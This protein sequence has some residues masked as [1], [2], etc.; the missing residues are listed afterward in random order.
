LSLCSGKQITLQAKS[1]LTTAPSAVIGTDTLL[2]TA[3]TYP[4]PFGHSFGGSKEQYLIPASELIATGL[5]P[6]NI[7]SLAVDVVQLP[8]IGGSVLQNF[9]IS[10]GRTNLTN[11]PPAVQTGINGM[12]QV[13]FMPFDTIQ[14][15]INTYTFITPF[16]WDG[17]SN[18]LLEI[19][20]NNN[21]N[22]GGQGG[23]AVVRQSLTNY[24]STIGY[25]ISNQQNV[26]STNGNASINTF[27]RR[28]NF[29]L[30]GLVGND[31]TTTL[32]WDWTPGNLSGSLVN[33]QA[34]T[35]GIN[36]YT[37]KATNSFGCTSNAS[38]NVNV[39]GLSPPP[40]A[41]NGSH[42]G[43]K[44]PECSVSGMTGI[45][46]WYLNP[47]GGIPLAGETSA[48]LNSYVIGTTTTFY[49]SEFDGLC[50]SIRVPVTETVI[51]TDS[52]NIIAS[53]P[54]VCQGIPLTL[55]ANQNGNTSNY[56]FN[57]TSSAGG[58]L[59][60]SNGNQVT[61]IPSL[62]GIVTYT[63][64][65]LDITSG[66]RWISN[67]NVTSNLSPAVTAT[68][69]SDS[70]CVGAAN[71]LTASANLSGKALQL[72]GI[73][74]Y[75]TIPPSASLDFSTNFTIELWMNPGSLD[76]GRG[77]L[78]KNQSNPNGSYF[79]RLGN[80]FP[81]SGLAA[82]GMN[83]INAPLG[84]LSLNTWYHVAV[85]YSN[86]SGTNNN[87]SIYLNGNL[88]VSGITTVN[89]NTDSLRIGIDY[90][91]VSFL[92]MIDE[93]RIWNSPLN[94]STIQ[95]WKNKPLDNS[96]PN[97][98]NLKTYFDFNF[99]SG[100]TV[101]DLSGNGNNAIMVNNAA[102]I[103][104]TAPLNVGFSYAWSPTNDLN[105]P[106]I[107]NPGVSSS[108]SGLKTYTV[109]ATSQSGCSSNSTTHFYA[110]VSAQNPV[111][112][113]TL[114]TT[115]FCNTGSDLLTLQNART[116]NQIR[117]QSSTDNIIWQDIPN[118]NGISLQTNILTITT[119][120]R[121][122]VSCT[123]SD[124]SNVIQLTIDVPTIT[125]TTGAT[126]CGSGQVSLQVTGNGNI[127]WFTNSTGSN[128]LF[129]GNIYQPNVSVSTTFWVE[130]NING[131]LF[132]GS[133]QPVVASVIPAPL[134]SSS[135]SA[136]LICSGTA[137]ILS[138]NSSND[139]NYSYVWTP[140]NFHGSTVPVSPNATTVYTVTATD[141]TLGTNNGCIA[142]STT[143]ISVSTTPPVAL[144][145]PSAPAICNSGGSVSLSI[146]NVFPGTVYRWNP[147]NFQGTSFTVSPSTTTTYTVTALRSPGCTSTANVTVYYSPI[148]QPVISSTSS[149][150]ICRG[151]S[152][153]L[154]TSANYSS[155]TW[156][157]GTTNIGSG[158]SITISPLSNFLC[159]LNVFNGLCSVAATQAI[160][161]RPFIPPSIT[162]ASNQTAFCEHD[163][164]LLSI[165]PSY[166]SYSWL[167][168]STSISNAQ[169]LYASSSGI[170]TATV[171]AANGCT[172]S[173]SISI[174]MNPAPPTAI[175]SPAGPILLC[176]DGSNS[177]TI[178][179]ADTTGS[180]PNSTLIWNDQGGTTN[181]SLSIN[182]DDLDIII[183]GNSF[184]YYF[185]ITN[186]FGC[187]NISN[188]V[189]AIAAPCS[190]NVTLNV[191]LFLEGYYTMGGNGLMNNQGAG[192]CLFI[193]GISTNPLD[194]DTITISLAD[195]SNLSIVQSA[196]G[197]LKT[198]GNVNV[199]FQ[200]PVLAGLSYYLIIKHRNSIETW[201][202]NPVMFNLATFYDFTSA[203]TQAY[204]D[205]MNHTSDG[206]FWAIYSG[207]I[208]DALTGS[209][210]IQDGMIESQDYADLENAT[211]II[212]VGYEI[213]DITGDGVVESVDYSI[214]ENNVNQV[215]QCIHP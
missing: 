88:I 1:F 119:Y 152:I 164:L 191:R 176:D 200:N 60:T 132:S 203:Q 135:S 118:A 27:Y 180:G 205:N 167:N 86:L 142:T 139:P 108:N 189:T 117:W 107:Y 134:I 52:I 12:T 159:S 202:S 124:T 120:F 89:I 40:V 158:P 192:G 198:D 56:S 129:N 193:N 122:I 19:C 121:V 104:S 100:T 174:S 11:L 55:I 147:G 212:L 214:M 71:Q 213:E 171:T 130:S 131:C 165:T 57:W 39:Y 168:G 37:V 137:A 166:L 112:A 128:S 177:P 58:G 5:Q 14:T 61:A 50:E 161:V 35:P 98:S 125:S 93:V 43:N 2:N 190:G 184:N 151:D 76:A 9:S 95:S 188:Q 140:G 143:Q 179:Q 29:R 44:V 185:T 13:L 148:I 49:V 105:N 149:F 187:S 199:T 194:V 77:L 17:I 116:G 22:G 34:T 182:H 80:A 208:S 81:F 170:Y 31:L 146:S 123:D 175:I 79:L 74:Q 186:S 64:D 18:L 26:C 207:D 36:T 138:V 21:D 102:I 206:F 73:N 20:F 127:N 99:P 32:T 84:S 183:N 3:S 33:T 83:T 162:S 23:N 54:S 101:P 178:F 48:T 163:S 96:H 110:S 94:I 15:G 153:I 141:T 78:S 215:I 42:C 144:I 172:A 16:N 8:L 72:D 155:Y 7:V 136:N 145:S 38:A 115:V 66:C 156:F 126:R 90:G 195:A 201:S 47:S 103:S 181:S 4:T 62:A 85:V 211:S 113:S 46:N 59:L 51:L 41:T 70:I 160:T 196:K 97:N 209:I 63:V 197:I 133:R 109:T 68:S 25:H 106:N 65:A 92:G 69:Q 67:F 111:I 204:G 28:P 24:I 53:S 91:N 154:N 6:G 45:F 173:K 10:M 169:N 82:G 210:G 150:N 30:G 157:N 75:L 87:V 114:G